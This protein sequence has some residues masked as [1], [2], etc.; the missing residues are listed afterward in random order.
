MAKR[1]YVVVTD[2]RVYDI[3]GV[4]L[5]GENAYYNFD[6]A[7]REFERKMDEIEQGDDL[8]YE[9]VKDTMCISKE[10]LSERWVEY[11]DKFSSNTLCL[12]IH[13]MKLK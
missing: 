3:D 8:D 12:F 7:K 6:D 1:I 2:N 13:E 10:W 5:V 11:K 9:W 4:A